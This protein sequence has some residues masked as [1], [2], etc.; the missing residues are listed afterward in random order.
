MLLTPEVRDWAREIV[1][2]RDLV[3]CAEE[4]ADVKKAVHVVLD[5]RDEA[6]AQ[7]AALTA[8]QEAAHA[9]NV[10]AW[11]GRT[12]EAVDEMLQYA[13]HSD[14]CAAVKV[15]GRFGS[16]SGTKW[17]VGD[18]ATCDCGVAAT[19]RANKTDPVTT[20]LTEHDARV[21]AATLEEAA[22][23]AL[24]QPYYVDTNVGTRQEWVKCEIA[25]K[26]RAIAKGGRP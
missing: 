8:S 26:L 20:T 23:L 6:R 19:A 22:Q 14:G 21:R 18:L 24:A 10:F 7:L 9:L 2:L 4:V 15:I 3:K 17:S 13:A 25:R 12:N 11:R 5:E 16:R 1:R